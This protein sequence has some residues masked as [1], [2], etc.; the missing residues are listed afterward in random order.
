MDILSSKVL[1]VLIPDVF[2]GIIEQM[3]INTISSNHSKSKLNKMNCILKW[4]P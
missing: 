2:Y 1:T 3:S 4:W